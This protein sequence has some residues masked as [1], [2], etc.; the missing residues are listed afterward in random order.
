MFSDHFERHQEKSAVKLS[1]F[2]DSTE[3][4]QFSLVKTWS[5]TVCFR[6]YT[7]Y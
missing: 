4:N 1:V 7:V 3:L 5:K 6:Q 2:G